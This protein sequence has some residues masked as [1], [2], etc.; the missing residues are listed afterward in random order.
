[1]ATVRNERVHSSQGERDKSFSEWVDLPILCLYSLRASSP[2]WMQWRA[3]GAFVCPSRVTF[4]GNYSCSWRLL[5][6]HSVTYS[7]TPAT[8]RDVDRHSLKR[9]LY[10]METCVIKPFVQIFFSIFIFLFFFYFYAHTVAF[11]TFS[12]RVDPKRQEVLEGKKE[13][14][15]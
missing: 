15:K 8:G 7:L 13:E 12:E 11:Q 9:A 2:F 3:R 10:T 5:S 6:S 14:E 1:M 4:H